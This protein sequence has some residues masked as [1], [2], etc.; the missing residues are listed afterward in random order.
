MLLPKMSV[1]FAAAL[2]EPGKLALFIRKKGI[3][4]HPLRLIGDGES[5]DLVGKEKE[6]KSGKGEAEEAVLRARCEM[7][8]MEAATTRMKRRKEELRLGG[9]GV[10]EGGEE[11]EPSSLRWST[12][13]S[14]PS[15]DSSYLVDLA[16]GE[17]KSRICDSPA[18]EWVE[19][20]YRQI[21]T[22]K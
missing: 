20:F 6:Q 18:A 5:E 8:N 11:V 9:G 15:P 17:Q 12:A 21:C 1:E 14:Q 19:I 7:A 4:T 2:A 22:S 13:T 16:E 10:G 3:G